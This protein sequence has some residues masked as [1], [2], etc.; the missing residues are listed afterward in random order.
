[1]FFLCLGLFLTSRRD[2]LS[3][4]LSPGLSEV[5]LFSTLGIG[6]RGGFR[7]YFSYFVASIL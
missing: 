3:K 4:N 7:L 6:V 1:M 5:F 2:G